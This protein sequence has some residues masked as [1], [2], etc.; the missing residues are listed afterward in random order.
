MKLLVCI[1]K[2]PDTT[3]KINFTENNT[4]FD[5]NGVNF[6]VNPYDEW[7]ALVRALELKE[8]NGGTVT[9]LNVGLAENDAVI[10][11]ALAIGADNAVRINVAPSD[12]VQVASEISSYAKSEGYDVIFFGKETIDGNNSLVSGLVAGFLDLPFVSYACKLDMNGNTATIQRDVAGGTET[13]EVETPF[14]VSAMKGLAEQR[15]P[16]MRGIMQARSKPL[17]VVEPAGAVELT[18]VKSYDKPEE[19][20]E[21]RYIDAANPAE[22]WDLLKNEAKVL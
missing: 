19:S 7:Y 1:S 17:T 10:R 9:I 4:K 3:S 18:S 6:I 20:A 16:N 15:I 14:V 5:E 21:C 13:V 8:A 12:S 22:L 2:V 11:K